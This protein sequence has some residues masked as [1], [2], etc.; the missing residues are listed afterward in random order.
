MTHT[1][2][3]RVRQPARGPEWLSDYSRSIENLFR[4]M[5]PG[6]LMLHGYETA[7]IP[8]AA[9]QWTHCLIYDHTINVVK[10]CTGTDWVRLAD[11]DADVAA[12]A[13]LSTTGLIAR[14][15]DGTWAARTLT[16]PAAGISVSNGDG[17][18]GN[19]TLALANDLAALEALSGTNTIYYRSGADTWSAVTVGSHLGFS[20]GTLSV[21]TGTSG[22][23][24]PL[25]NGNNTHSGTNTF[26]A[27]GNVFQGDTIF[28]TS[29]TAI[30]NVHLR[31][32]K[33]Q[34]S[35]TTAGPRF[36]AES[37]TVTDT[38]SSG[39]ATIATRVTFSIATPTFASTNAITVTNAITWYIANP[40]SAGTNTSITNAWAFWIN[41]GNMNLQSGDLYRGGTK[42]VG[43][44]GAAV[45]DAT[46]AGDVV[47]QLNALL[48][49]LR[50][51]GL[52]AT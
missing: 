39:G 26:S 10:H 42:V 9:V 50:T 20:G 32:N 30:A 7:E 11:Y 18:S 8:D 27:S 35:W 25:L 31:G 48:A 6:P 34:A 12:I 52:I 3:F 17:V 5:M 29:G 36:H 51:H 33:S 24:I 28:G 41:S 49:R 13:G 1:I 23:A 40:P 44:Q 15:G 47:A 14:T 21:S 19:P 16:A 2:S 46:G 38:S 22:A 4:Q 45:A 43:A 37:A